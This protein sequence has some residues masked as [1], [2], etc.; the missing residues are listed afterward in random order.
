LAC[1]ALAGQSWRKPGDDNE[2]PPG[3]ENVSIVGETG[4]GHEME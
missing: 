3:S 4:L 2:C 1:A